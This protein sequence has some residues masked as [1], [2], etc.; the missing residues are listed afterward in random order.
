M[1][2]S[3]MT[4]NAARS[5]RPNQV[6]RTGPVRAETP[7]RTHPAAPPPSAAAERGGDPTAA[8][9]DAVQRARAAYQ[10]LRRIDSAQR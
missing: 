6:F 1:T 4:P 3:S 9:D 2:A 10:T 8:V 7:G 5:R